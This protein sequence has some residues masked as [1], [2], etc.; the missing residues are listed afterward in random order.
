[1]L[2]IDQDLDI[3]DLT[4]DS[5]SSTL[6]KL[7]PGEILDVIIRMRQLMKT[8]ETSAYTLYANFTELGDATLEQEADKARHT[9]EL[10]TARIASLLSVLE[11]SPHY[12]DMRKQTLGRRR[13]RNGQ[14][15]DRKKD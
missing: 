6:R 10:A 12:V 13:E 11:R 1:M 15:L 7:Q 14:R 2:R 9:L 4:D 8:L 5:P 3:L